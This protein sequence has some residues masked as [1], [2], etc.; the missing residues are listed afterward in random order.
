MKFRGHLLQDVIAKLNV[1]FF[2]SF[3]LEGSYREQLESSF[4]AVAGGSYGAVLEQ[5]V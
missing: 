2:F 3:R 1:V 4:G 5:T